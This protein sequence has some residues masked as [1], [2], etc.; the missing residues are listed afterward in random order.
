MR[1]YTLSEDIPYIKRGK[2]VCVRA[3]SFTLSCISVYTA[4][5][6]TDLRTYRLLALSRVGTCNCI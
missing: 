2:S 4:Y 3:H 6:R 1:G 5:S